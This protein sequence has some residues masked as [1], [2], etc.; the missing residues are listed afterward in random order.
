[1]G[2]K[3]TGLKTWPRQWQIQ[4][5]TESKTPS[6]VASQNEGRSS[7]QKGRQVQGVRSAAFHGEKPA[8]AISW[9]DYETE[10]N[11]RHGATMEAMQ[12]LRPAFT[13][14]GSVT[15]ANASGLN[16]GAAAVMLMSA[17]E[18]EKRGLTPLS[19]H[20]Q[21]RNRRSGPVY[22]GG[23]PDLCQPQGAGKGR[24]EARGLDLIEANEAF[25]AQAC[26]VNK[27]MAGIRP[28]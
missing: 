26:A 10:Y 16:D 3:A 23:R 11:F 7:A 20:R 21:L 25:A 14:D 5:R 9:V 27:D 24:L 18:A 1:M 4:P 17:E 2:T 8:R 12:K 19:A 15:A 13:K 22:H 28:R 6:A